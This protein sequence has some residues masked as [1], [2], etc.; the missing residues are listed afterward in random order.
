LPPL[1]LRGGTGKDLETK[2]EGTFDGRQSLGIRYSQPCPW[3]VLGAPFRTRPRPAA[4]KL[5]GNVNP[6]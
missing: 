1:S 4:H 5:L 2:D 6:Q 3:G